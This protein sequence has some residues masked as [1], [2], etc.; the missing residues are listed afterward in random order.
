M[1]KQIRVESVKL[2]IGDTVLD[3]SL[4]DARALR[5][6]LDAALP[7]AKATIEKVVHEHRYPYWWWGNYRHMNTGG[8]LVAD[9]QPL[10]QYTIYC[11]KD[12]NV[13]LLA[14]VAS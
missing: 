6:A 1:S 4:E 13:S 2:K 12:N 11:S 7:G 14:S 9:T 3:L 5:D 8:T 10:T